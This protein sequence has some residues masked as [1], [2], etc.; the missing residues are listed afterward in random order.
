MYKVEALTREEL[1]DTLRD[2]VCS[3]C[4][5]TLSF[6][7]VDQKRYAI[8]P[9]CKEDTQG[10]TSRKFADRKREESTHEYEEARRNLSRLLGWKQ[11]HHT[12]QENLKALGF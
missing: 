12:E 3:T 9:R 6:V 1:D 7:V 8:C 11:G 2:Y 5:G 10:Y 4:W